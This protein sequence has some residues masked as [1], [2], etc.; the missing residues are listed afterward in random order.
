MEQPQNLMT[1]LQEE[2]QKLQEDLDQVRRELTELNVS[3]PQ[4]SAEVDRLAQR[5]LTISSRQ[6]EM[7]MNIESY[8]RNDI[9][10]FFSS[11]HE[12]QMRLY[13]MRTQLEQQQNKQKSLQDR[14]RDLQ[15]MLA[16]LTDVSSQGVTSSTAAMTDGDEEASE[17]EVISRIIQAQE[18]ERQ[19]ISQQIHDGP[20]QTMSNLVLQAE[21]CERFIDKDPEEAKAEL[22]GLKTTIH[23][24]LQEMRRFIFDVRPMI[25]D[26]LGLVP[27]LRRYLQDF[28]ERNNIQANLVL[29]GSESRMPKHLEISLFRVIQEALTNVAKHAHAPHAR[30]ALE[31]EEHKITV[32]VED[33]GVGFNV[34][35][36]D[37][38]DRRGSRRMGIANMRQRVEK[39]LK[40]RLQ[41]ES[42]PGKGTRILATIP[43]GEGGTSTE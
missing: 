14:Q 5:E 21:V 2:V 17:Q 41:I 18:E 36:I 24:T 27:T 35:E 30:V 4:N 39:L 20:T 42:T 13:M 40:G 3:I 38:A 11:L 33:D 19:R 9:R 15:T 7:D 8:P 12:V 23:H 6:R 22:A 1:R 31:I 10:Q 16:L 28:G 25:L 26:D 34:A 29:Q 43:L 37:Q 32:A